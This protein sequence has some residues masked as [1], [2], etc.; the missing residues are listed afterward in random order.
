MVCTHG[1]LPCH[2]VINVTFDLNTISVYFQASVEKNHWISSL[3]KQRM[4]A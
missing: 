4:K 2:F 3:K 1:Y